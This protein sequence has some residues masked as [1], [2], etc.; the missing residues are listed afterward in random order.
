MKMIKGGVYLLNKDY[1]D[2]PRKELYRGDAVVLKKYLPILK[3]AIVEFDGMKF[4]IDPSYLEFIEG[5]AP[6]ET[7]DEPQ[8][9]AHY[10]T[11]IDT[12]DFLRANCP[13]EQV[14]GFLRGNALKYL[15]RYDK[16]NG[17]E[18]LRKAKHYVGMLIEELEG[19]E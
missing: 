9:P 13:P 4:S 10:D 12:I 1:L 7:L 5:D 14:E 8:K 6:V 16:K 17:L 2:D 3:Q 11:G 18:D 19:R 15:Q